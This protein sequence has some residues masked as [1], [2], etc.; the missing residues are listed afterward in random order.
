M[1]EWLNLPKHE[2]VKRFSKRVF[3]KHIKLPIL[4]VPKHGIEETHQDQNDS[5]TK[6][7]YPL[8]EKALF[9]FT[10]C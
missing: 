2:R 7:E 1:G 9:L 4:R 6:P 5:F 3:K 10:Y 8:N